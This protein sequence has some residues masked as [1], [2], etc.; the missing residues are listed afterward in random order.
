MNKIIYPSMVDSSSRSNVLTNTLAVIGGSVLLVLCSQIYITLPFTPVP[1]TAQ[2]LSVMFLGS[3]LG[4]KKAPLSVLLYVLYGALGFPVFSQHTGGVHVLVGATGGY[5]FGFLASAYIIGKFTE[6]GWDRFLG[7]SLVAMFIGQFFI[8][9]PGLLW[10]SRYVG[11]ENVLFQG[12]Y[13]FI[14]GGI[15]KTLLAGS[16]SVLAWKLI[17]RFKGERYA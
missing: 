5:I 7:K 11:V 10:L 15:I 9:V 12:F 2:T 6:K 17:D 3:L 1:I 8:F 14:I 16:S 13:P 4:S